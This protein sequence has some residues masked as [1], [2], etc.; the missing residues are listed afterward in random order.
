MKINTKVDNALVIDNTHE[1]FKDTQYAEEEF[2]ITLQMDTSSNLSSLTDAMIDEA[3]RTGNNLSDNVSIPSIT[4]WKLLSH[5]V[6]W[7]GFEDAD[8]KELECTLENKSKFYEATEYNDFFNIIRKIKDDHVKKIS[9]KA[10][11][12]KEAG[13]K[14]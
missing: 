5:I 13:K 14:L 10:E 7:V 3:S 4:K 9:E 11:A 6:S 2:I 8:G 12:I 1:L